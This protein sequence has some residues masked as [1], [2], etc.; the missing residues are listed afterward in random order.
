MA[1][2]VV[3]GKEFIILEHP[4]R[5]ISPS[6]RDFD[7]CGI[8]GICKSSKRKYNS[9]LSEQFLLDLERFS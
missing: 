2:H 3:N 8:V 9:F 5:L 7:S 1:F 6:P 4:A